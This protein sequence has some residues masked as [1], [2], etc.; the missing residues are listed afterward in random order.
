MILDALYW[1]L[2]FCGIGVAWIIAL[3]FLLSHQDLNNG[4][5]TAQELTEDIRC[6]YPIEMIMHFGIGFSFFVHSEF[7]VAICCL[8]MCFYNLKI[9][10]K[11]EIRCYA[12]FKE[13]FKEKRYMERMALVKFLFNSAMM[14]YVIIRFILSLTSGV[15]GL[16]NYYHDLVNTI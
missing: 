14:G 6:Y 1:G 10:L 5:T 12:M 16:L 2:M 8:P 9:I 4:K 15:T 3:Y 13:D 11:R 7:I